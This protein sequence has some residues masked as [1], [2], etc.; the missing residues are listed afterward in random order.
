[1]NRTVASIAFL[2]TLLPGSDSRPKEGDKPHHDTSVMM[3][4]GMQVPQPWHELEYSLIDYVEMQ[5]GRAIIV[6]F[7][8]HWGTKSEGNWRVLFSEEVTES[9]QSSGFLCLTGDLTE[10][11]SSLATSEMNGLGR[12]AV[13]VTAVYDPANG[14][15]QVKPEVFSADDVEQWIRALE[16]TK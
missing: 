2:S 6:S 5:P 12:V 1:M 10:P 16:K 14:A 7:G 4:Q 8:A 11:D 15:W 9:L 13:P 3:H